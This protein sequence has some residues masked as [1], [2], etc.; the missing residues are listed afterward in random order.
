V[1]NVPLGT[2]WSYVIAISGGNTIKLTI[3]GTTT[4]YSIPSSF[5][6]YHQYFKAGDYNQSSS[7]S[8]SNGAKVKFYALSVSHS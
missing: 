2:Q 4:S 7:S 1:G 5:N 8:T 6:Q 3:N